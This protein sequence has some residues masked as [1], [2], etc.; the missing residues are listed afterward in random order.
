MKQPG[1]AYRLCSAP[2]ATSA[3]HPILFNTFKNTPKILE[4]T[5]KRVFAKALPQKLYLYAI[6]LSSSSH[7]S[8]GCDNFSILSKIPPTFWK[9]LGTP[10][11]GPRKCQV[12]RNSVQWTQSTYLNLESCRYAGACWDDNDEWLMHACPIPQAFN[13]LNCTNCLPSPSLTGLLGT[14][15]LHWIALWSAQKVY[16]YFCICMSNFVLEILVPRAFQ[17]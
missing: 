1:S 13:L 9:C 14:R 10:V 2:P 4:N 7:V 6:L 3:L 5:L 16:L 15:W 17:K 11:T 12:D 8:P